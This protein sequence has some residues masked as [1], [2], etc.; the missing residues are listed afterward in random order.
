M[1]KNIGRWAN[2][3]FQLSTMCAGKKNQQS[4]FKIDYLCSLFIINFGH[5][6]LSLFVLRR[7]FTI[8]I[9]PRMENE[10]P[11]KVMLCILVMDVFMCYKKINMN[12]S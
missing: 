9:I 6:I 12:Y 10:W 2:T 5:K 1:S 4:L 8:Q 3:V 7:K 11:M